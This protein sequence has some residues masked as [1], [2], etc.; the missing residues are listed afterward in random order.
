MFSLYTYPSSV[1][2]YT[3]AAAC[4][5]YCY[6][7]PEGLTRENALETEY[8]FKAVL[9]PGWQDQNGDRSGINFTGSKAPLLL[10]P[11]KLLYGRNIGFRIID[12]VPS[13]HLDGLRDMQ[14]LRV[15]AHAIE[16]AVRDLLPLIFGNI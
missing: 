13:R 2:E 9:R 15:V 11:Y 1:W 7:A 5:N 10:F 16:G 8:P 6:A 12:N 14:E 3:M 4:I